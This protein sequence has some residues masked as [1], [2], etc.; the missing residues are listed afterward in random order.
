LRAEESSSMLTDEL[1]DE[2]RKVR[3]EVAIAGS[4]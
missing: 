4:Q 3:V 1:D 2:R